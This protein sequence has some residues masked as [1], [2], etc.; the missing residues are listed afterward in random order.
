MRLFILFVFLVRLAVTASAPCFIS[1]FGGIDQSP[2]TNSNTPCATIAF[3]LRDES[4]DTIFIQSDLNLTQSVSLQTT[5]QTI[6]IGASPGNHPVLTCDHS[7]A[8]PALVLESSPL[9]ALRALT[10]SHLSFKGCHAPL[11][12]AVLSANLSRP[13]FLLT[14]EDCAMSECS[15]PCQ[16]GCVDISSVV[17]A[18]GVTVTLLRS[19]FTHAGLTQDSSTAT[20]CPSGGS[21]G[22]LHLAGSG[23]S[24]NVTECLF[25]DDHAYL[26]GGAISFRGSNTSTL[27]IDRSIFRRCQ[28]TSPTNTATLGGGALWADLVGTVLIRDTNFAECGVTSKKGTAAGGA[29]WL[30][31]VVTSARFVRATWQNNTVH[32][33]T[34]QGGAATVT[35]IETAPETCDLWVDANTFMFNTATATGGAYAGALAA[36]SLR[37]ASL[38]DSNIMSNTA[39]GAAS[40]F[41]GA[42]LLSTISAGVTLRAASF[43]GNSAVGGVTQ[44]GA[45]HLTGTAATTGI[46]VDGCSFVSNRAVS[47]SDSADG[48]GLLVLSVNTLQVV[49]TTFQ[50][51]SLSSTKAARGGGLRSWAVHTVLRGVTSTGNSLA[52]ESVS[53]G[54]GA[55][56]DGDP[57]GD[58]FVA[59]G[60]M[61]ENSA[62]SSI[63]FGGALFLGG[64][65]QATVQTMSWTG[66]AARATEQASGS[67]FFAQSPGALVLF[68]LTAVNNTAQSSQTL[69]GG[70]LSVDGAGRTQMLIQ[71]CTFTT[72]RGLSTS[73][74]AGAYGGVVHTKNLVALFV[75]DSSFHQNSLMG[76]NPWAGALFHTTQINSIFSVQRTLFSEN[77]AQSG[78]SGT[79]VCGGAL[80]ADGPQSLGIVN[81]TFLANSAIHAGD[82]AALG[83]ALFARGSTAVSVSG[84]LFRGCASESVSNAA[85]GALEVFLAQGELDFSNTWFI[86][87]TASSGKRASLSNGGFTGGAVA[88]LRG[89]YA[90]ATFNGCFFHDNSVVTSAIGTG[91]ALWVDTIGGG[92]TLTGCEF[93]RNMLEGE[94]CGGGA[95]FLTGTGHYKVEDVTVAD[96]VIGVGATGSTGGAAVIDGQNFTPAPT[97]SVTR[98]T[99]SNNKM[100][101]AS[102]AFGGGMQIVF[103][104]DVQIRQCRFLNNSIGSGGGHAMGAGLSVTSLLAG[105]P[106]EMEDLEVSGNAITS[107]TDAFGGG[108]SIY[109]AFDPTIS[110]ALSRSLFAD[111]YAVADG[112]CVGG[113]LSVFQL[114]NVSLTEVDFHRNAI[115]S[116]SARGGALDC[117]VT[118]N[119]KFVTLDHVRFFDNAATGDSTGFGGASSFELAPSAEFMVVNCT[120]VRNGVVSGKTSG[121]ALCLGL[122]TGSSS[123]APSWRIIE[124]QFEGSYII[125]TNHGQ[126]WGT[127]S[128]GAIYFMAAHAGVTLLQQCTITN[129]TV[130]ASYSASGAALAGVASASA[131]LVIRECV[132]DESR[133][134]SSREATG[135][136]L[137]FGGFRSILLDQCNLTRSYVEGSM[138]ATGGAL[139]GEDVGPLLI[140]D[141]YF[142]SGI[143]SSRATGQGGCLTLLGAASSPARFIN[144]MFSTCEAD[145]GGAILSEVPLVLEQC[146]LVDCV[147]SGRG[148]G[149]FTRAS[150]KFVGGECSR[151]TAIQGGCMITNE[152]VALTLANLTLEA[153][154]VAMAG[155][156]IFLADGSKLSLSGS[157]ARYNWV[158]DGSGAVVFG[159]YSTMTL[160][161]N[162]FEENRAKLGAALYATNC[163]VN[164]AG[165]T[166]EHGVADS[167]AAWCLF[168][169]EL[170]SQGDVISTS[171][172]RTGAVFL[173]GTKGTVSDTRF[174]RNR[175]TSGGTI[176]ASRSNITIHNSQ[177][178]QSTASTGGALYFEDNSALTVVSCEFHSCRATSGAVLYAWQQ[179]SWSFVDC[180]F[181]ENHAEFGGAICTTFEQNLLL[182]GCLFHRNQATLAGSAIY[183]LW[184]VTW[185]PVGTPLFAIAHSEFRANWGASASSATGVPEGSTL[186]LSS[187]AASM[188]NTTFWTNLGGAIYAENSTLHLGQGCRFGGNRA[189][190]SKATAERPMNIWVQDESLLTVEDPEGVR[191]LSTGALWVYTDS[192]SARVAAE[193]EDPLLPLLTGAIQYPK[194]GSLDFETPLLSVSVQLDRSDLLADHNP[195]CYIVAA[196]GQLVQPPTEFSVGNASRAIGSC[197]LDHP[198]TDGVY[199]VLLSNDG[200]RNVSVGHFRLSTSYTALY[201]IGGATGGGMFLLVMGGFTAYFLIRWLRLRRA[202]AIELASWKTFQVASIDFTNLKIRERIGHGA[203]GEVFRGDLNGTVVAVKRLFDTTQSE[204][205]LAEFRREVS[206]MRTLRHP[207]RLV[208]VTVFASALLLMGFWVVVAAVLPGFCSGCGPQ[209]I[210]GLVGATFENPKLIITEYMGRGSLYVILHNDAIAL[211]MELRLRMA[212]DMARGLNYLHTLRP[213]ILHR[214]IK[215]QNMLVT[216]DM[217]VKVSDFGISRLTQEAGIATAA[218]TPAWSAPEVLR[219]DR[220]GLPSDVYSFGVVLW[221][222]ITRRPLGRG[223]SPAVMMTVAREDGRL[224]I[225]SAS[226]C[227]PIF[228]DL[229][230]Q[231]FEADPEKRPSMQQLVDL[232]SAECERHPYVD[233]ALVAPRKAT[234]TGAAG[235]G[236]KKRRAKGGTGSSGAG[237]V[238]LTNVSTGS[239]F[240]DLSS[241]SMASEPLLTEMRQAGGSIH[242]FFSVK[243]R[244]GSRVRAFHLVSGGRNN[245]T[246]ACFRTSRGIKPFVS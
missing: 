169:S 121:G 65:A 6:W 109:C 84:S 100:T 4:C 217:R 197:R 154:A 115:R 237:S 52:G 192:S 83:G 221:E 82:G 17:P 132:F 220:S 198:N 71:Q 114:A 168:S 131:E 51:N 187:V 204:T 140:S 111:N 63:V 61:T 106:L 56:L 171:E 199:E 98:S 148:G 175:A 150:V 15:A 212:F 183:F 31:N 40:A 104:R 210:V 53:S 243:Y 87:N 74:K 79:T 72:N 64:V 238:P 32:G 196:D 151:C 163:V 203:A 55:F 153:N 20:A 231:C 141:S 159:R 24:L 239:S 193:I 136:A 226:E 240:L 78:A 62:V 26:G 225:P 14:I 25:S 116:G 101:S 41:G 242:F 208:S 54:A 138:S 222:L 205:Q 38:T 8:F 233:A 43:S 2:C 142:L 9:D 35:G 157:T 158:Q 59:D 16:G 173:S 184:W 228:S 7:T 118:P 39:N 176:Y 57:Q 86:E 189:A 45:V 117:G 22:A 139:F 68:G 46:L 99:F 244:A 186:F 234:T 194:E 236:S 67:V 215:S 37:S 27:T 130:R 164:S 178:Q 181:Q 76:A 188:E 146:Q 232:L 162:R 102:S 219:G 10:L 5:S 177:F 66:N 128:G 216:D 241:S 160:R 185:Q 29:V 91:G 75:V 60:A 166:Y 147:A 108:I 135:G 202:S 89:D 112:E 124:T 113:A 229:M 133:S 172:A 152:G 58:V 50:Q 93:R 180:T 143:A 156:A 224:P 90:H 211:P 73:D 129:S 167:G 95:F 218:G 69:L 21:G 119:S 223:A 190:L 49:G 36:D 70:V 42:V 94:M 209:F 200:L 207:V 213:P 85:G 127:G 30:S 165:T 246:V 245:N 77:Q 3:A 28:A 161:D 81:C 34:C 80:A 144:T 105:A 48:G 23:V 44:G 149:I 13:D 134:S 107:S 206:M 126:E 88:L 120:F 123:A 182:S 125:A 145:D 201:I 170:A 12:G 96:T 33:Q 155:A 11:S 97:A 227:P 191:D 19:N 122:D 47:K 103:A 230:R 137:Y 195:L 110:L 18:S 92:V 1:G 174:L 235:G 179:S 214:D